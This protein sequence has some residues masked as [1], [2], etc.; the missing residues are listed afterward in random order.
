MRIALNSMDALKRI[1][2][3][4]SCDP[5]KPALN[6]MV[7]ESA[8]LGKVYAAATNGFILAW[9]VLDLV[10][11]DEDLGTRR[12]IIPGKLADKIAMIRVKKNT[13]A[14]L[15]ITDDEARLHLHGLPTQSMPWVGGT[16]CFPRWQ[17]VLPENSKFEP[18]QGVRFNSGWLE[19]A[20]KALG[21]KD[22]FLYIAVRH[23]TTAI[24]AHNGVFV[25]LAAITAIGDY[26]N[27]LIVQL[28]D[29]MSAVPLFQ[30]A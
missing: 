12:L 17:K 3:A 11:K 30:A 23:K 16:T 29:S 18:L 28:R 19:M 4:R 7:L 25:Q 1:T 24:A 21:N 22:G 8:G 20:G 14:D 26:E 13:I 6:G 5:S 2:F 27:D 10:E 15:E 9:G